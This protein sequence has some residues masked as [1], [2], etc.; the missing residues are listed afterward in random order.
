MGQFTFSLD[1]FLPYKL[2]RTAEQ[3]ADSLAELYQKEF[4]ITR[5]EWRI[6][7]NLGA[8]EDVIARD[9]SDVT[10][11]DKVK[12]SRTLARL[13]EKELITREKT[14]NDQRATHIQLTEKGQALYE[15]II[16]RALQWESEILDGLTGSQYRD[17]F[18]ALDALKQSTDAVYQ[19]HSGK[20]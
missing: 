14:E 13:E 19:K 12:V 8:R 5:P 16:P 1:E 7:A 10:N 15:R 3:V 18:R 20:G 9:L 4:G 6:I 11:L 17:L 2:V